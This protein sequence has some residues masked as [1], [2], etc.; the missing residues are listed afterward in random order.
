MLENHVRT[1]DV[2][3]IT[4]AT[5][6]TDICSFAPLDQP[7]ERDGLGLLSLFKHFSVPS[8]FLLERLQ[9]VTHGFGSFGDETGCQCELP[10]T[11]VQVR[12]H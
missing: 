12:S 6:E 3:R 11:L 2:F 7:G 9:A 4:P 1:L 8:C 5:P 10:Y